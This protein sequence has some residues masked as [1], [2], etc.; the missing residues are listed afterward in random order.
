MNR[1]GF[2]LIATIFIVIAVALF[3]ITITY[4]ISSSSRVAVLN[5]RS[6]NAFYIANGGFQYYLNQLKQDD[7]W[8]TPPIQETKVFSDGVFIIS[9][10]DEETSRI[11]VTV[12]ALYTVEGKTYKRK[13]RSTVLGNPW[14]FTEE[15]IIYWGGGGYSGGETD[16]K[17]DVTIDGNVFVDSDIDLRS[18]TVINGDVRATGNVT[19]Y[20][21]GVTGTIETYVD[22]PEN[23]PHVNEDHYNALIAVAEA[24]PEADQT[25][26]GTNDL[27]G[28]IFVDGDCLFDGDAVINI[29]GSAT[30]VAT[31]TFYIDNGVTLGEHLTVIA[32]GNVDFKNR[33]DSGKSNQWY[34][35]TKI[36]IKNAQSAGDV[37]FR[38]GNAFITAGNIKFGN[39][40]WF[41]GLLFCEGSLYFGNNNEYEGNMIAGYVDQIGSYSHLVLNP[42]L[43]GYEEMPGLDP[44]P[45]K[46]TDIEMWDEIY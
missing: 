29:T 18:G 4:F 44:G 1:K 25:W 7:D 20:T 31:G 24:S 10:T 6:L 8:S 19:G 43:V 23:V 11:T 33:V 3:A 5:Y 34:S 13:L 28:W 39:N 26:S 40:A 45:I 22:P 36:E 38:E 27:S 17:S 41:N 21:E 15:Y 42:G 14:A 46:P 32:G 30:I 35:S 16:I 12:T 2:A 9:T 37:N